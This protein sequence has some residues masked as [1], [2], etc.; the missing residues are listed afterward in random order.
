MVND[1]YY[2]VVPLIE[3]GELLKDGENVKVLS[4]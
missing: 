1:V 2:P 3:I 4:F